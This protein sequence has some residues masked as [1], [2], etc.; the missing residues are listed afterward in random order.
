MRVFRGGSDWQKR[1]RCHGKTESPNTHTP[2]EKKT[3]KKKW[4][5]E[6]KKKSDDAIREWNQVDMFLSL[7]QCVCVWVYR[8]AYMFACAVEK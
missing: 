2:K 5:W 4:Q 3:E 7:I 1:R 8:S 6:R